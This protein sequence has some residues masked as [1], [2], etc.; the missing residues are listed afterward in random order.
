MQKEDI[1]QLASLSRIAVTDAEVVALQ[2]E[3][4]SILEYVGQIQA[5]TSAVDQTKVP[6]AVF[7][8]MRADEVTNMPG[9][10]T[11]AIL[12]EMPAREGDFM[13]VKKILTADE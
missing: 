3:I 7:N 8:V 12:G 10:Y 13:K 5:M 11:E 1:R 9:Q 6:G 4:G 2:T